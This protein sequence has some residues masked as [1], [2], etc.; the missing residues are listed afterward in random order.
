M[1]QLD[2]KTGEIVEVKYEATA[3]DKDKSLKGGS[4]MAREFESNISKCPS[5]IVVVFEPNRPSY[6]LRRLK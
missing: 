5:E 4:L 6:E 1:K 2:M 3:T